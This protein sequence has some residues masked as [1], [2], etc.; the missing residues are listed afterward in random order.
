MFSI[1][2]SQSW[3]M[4]PNH[5]TSNMKWQDYKTEKEQ[6]H[7]FAWDAKEAL[8]GHFGTVGAKN[9]QKIYNSLKRLWGKL[10]KKESSVNPLSIKT[11]LK[12]FLLCYPELGW[13]PE[14]MKGLTNCEDVNIACALVSSVWDG[15]YYYD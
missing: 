9:D 7:S 14:E 3:G 1:F 5:K 15:S 8:T 6:R 2:V 11:P 13:E 10:M 12:I 4:N